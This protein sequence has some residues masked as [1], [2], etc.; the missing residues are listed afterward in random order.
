[1]V[2]QLISPAAGVE[3]GKQ[4]LGNRSWLKDAR[5][6]DL[7]VWTCSIMNLVLIEIS[8]CTHDRLIVEF[9]RL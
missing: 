2:A 4:G 9:S 8:P 6:M 1:M 5:Y 3:A 7:H